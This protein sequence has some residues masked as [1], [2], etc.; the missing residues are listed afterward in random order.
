MRTK[1]APPQE[2]VEEP[3]KRA[4]PGTEARPFVLGESLPVVPAKLVRR[5]LKGDYI[6]MSEFLKDNMEADRRRALMESD[7]AGS[8]FSNKPLRRE[9]PD[10]MSWLQCFSAYAAV[11]GSQYPEKAKELWAYQAMIIGEARRCGGRG[12]A[13]YDSA[14]RQRVSSLTEVDFSKLNQALYSTTFLAYG[15]RGRFCA[16]CS[17]SDHTPEECALHPNRSMPVIQLRGEFGTTGHRE[18]EWAERP[19]ETKRQRGPSVRPCFAWNDGKCAY[20]NCRFDHVCARCHG[21]HRKPACRAK[22]G[23]PSRQREDTQRSG[24]P[25]AGGSGD[26]GP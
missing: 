14:F 6:D 3:P 21:A 1:E 23:A 16:S 12:W 8:S 10:L 18:R 20:Q 2:G 11:V 13:L 17:M 25:P 26:A 4:E 7:G 15:G 19:P 24:R 9:V 5:I 22:E